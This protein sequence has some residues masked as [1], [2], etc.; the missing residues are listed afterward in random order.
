MALYKTLKKLKEELTEVE[1]MVPVNNMGKWYKS[2]R[3]NSIKSKIE[4][5]ETKIKN[6]K[7]K[8]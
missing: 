2:V 8:K 3:T 1:N 7:T 6:N 4:K 5:I